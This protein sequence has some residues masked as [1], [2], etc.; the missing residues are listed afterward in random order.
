MAKYSGSDWDFEMIENIWEDIVKI[1][2]KYNL[3]YYEPQ[4][5]IISSEQKNASGIKEEKQTSY[6]EKSSKKE[7]EIGVGL[8]IN[9]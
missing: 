1:A 8:V 9:A 2:S 6:K 7:K 3:D 4:I 5:E